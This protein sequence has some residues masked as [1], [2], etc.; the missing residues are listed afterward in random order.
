[1]STRLSDYD[2][3]LPE[4]LIAQAPAEPRDTS[5]LLVVD[6]ARGKIAHHQ[7]LDLPAFLHAG[8]LMVANNTRVLRARLLGQRILPNG[9]RGGRVEF[10][11][12]ERVGPRAWEGLMKA[13]AKYLPGLEFEVPVPAL[14]GVAGS[15]GQFIRGRLVRG[16]IPGAQPTVVAEF[17]RDP[18][19]A[20][21]GELPLPPYIAGDLA[22]AEASY[23]TIYAQAEP[24]SAAAPTAGLHFTPRVFEALRARGVDW[25]EVTLDVGLGTFRPVKSD[26][27]RAHAMHAERYGISEAGARQIQAARAEGRRIVAVGTT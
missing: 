11:M 22:Q 23:Q 7:F 20:G 19:E 4:S 21:A 15:A 13:S 1:M 27:I 24:G 2:F 25:A 6:R 26:D 17:D 12:L 10:L 16:A 5:R 14:S 18:V 3:E 9:E 8:D